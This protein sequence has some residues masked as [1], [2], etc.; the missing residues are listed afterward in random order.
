MRRLALLC[1]AT[2]GVVASL[3]LAATTEPRDI[4][5]GLEG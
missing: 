4:I 2:L 1:K 5:A 3:V